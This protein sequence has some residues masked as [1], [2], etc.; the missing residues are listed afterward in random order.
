MRHLKLV[1]M[2]T[3]LPY[4]KMLLMDDL[5]EFRIKV[6]SVLVRKD[7]VQ[8]CFSLQNKKC[9]KDSSMHGNA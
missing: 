1:L 6:F 9:S 2:T 7:K 4:L 3:Q 5:A 8:N